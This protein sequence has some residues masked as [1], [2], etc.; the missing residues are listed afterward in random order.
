MPQDPDRVSAFMNIRVS[1]IR[2]AYESRA[3]GTELTEP[4]DHARE[5]RDT[6]ATMAT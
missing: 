4:K 1:D 6:C 2:K 3:A 5:I